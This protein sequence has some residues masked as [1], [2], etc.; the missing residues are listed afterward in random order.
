MSFSIRKAV[1]SDFI[2]LSQLAS[3]CFSEAFARYNEK[4]DFEAYLAESF[5]EEKIKEELSDDKNIFLI[6]EDDQK[7]PLGYAKLTW[8]ETPPKLEGRNII[9]VQRIYART[10]ALGTGVGAALMQKCI[11]IAK[12]LKKEV[13]WLGVWQENKRAIDFYLRWGFEIFGVKTFKIGD[14]V[15]DDYVMK[16]EL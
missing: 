1:T 15:D 6:L 9:Q 3:V 10:A 14:K 16:K 13:I 5:S 8:K 7:E 11:D 12:E 4:E 2:L